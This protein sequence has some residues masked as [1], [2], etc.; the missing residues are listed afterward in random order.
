[1]DN[2][3]YNRIVFRLC[4][5]ALIV[6]SMTFAIRA[7]ILGQLGGDFGLTD[8]ELGWVN[9][10][11]F[12]GFPVATM[13]GG[14]IYN[15]IGA[16][17]LVALAFICHLL[18]LAL[19][20]TAD[21]FWGLLVSTFLIG[22]ANG[23]VEAGCNPLIAEMYPKNATTML[24][25]FHVWFPGGIVIGA[26]ASNFM[27]A[28]GLNW[29]WQ[30]ALILVP[31]IIYGAML[32]KAKFPTFDTRIHSTSSNIRHLFTPLYL[33]LIACMTLTATTEFGTQQWIER[34]L[35]SSGASPMVILALI[36][37]LMAV[38]RFFAGPIVH[39]LN[40]TGVLLGSALCASL[41]I[42]MMSQA[43]GT[44]IYLAAILFAMGVTYFWPTML[45][46]VAEYIPKSGALGMSLMGGAGM[47]AM[48][49]WNPVIGSWIDSARLSAKAS[50]ASAEQIEILA[51]Q[52]VLQNLLI[53]PII[54]IVAFIGLH[55]VI[56]NNKRA[57]KC[58]S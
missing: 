30:V 38:G 28:A 32:I 2:N 21:G 15:A 41:G 19:T 18:G 43:Q 34:I 45:G 53:F 26:L 40:P 23:S 56:N 10:M 33:F 7:G 17:K 25:R 5:I 27:S 4:C 48:S 36:T 42:F 6:T 55:L 50:G 20:I 16:K 9:A 11:A 29:Q 8:T 54:L 31:T 49:I 58:A 35:G 39:K 3:N 24:N 51:G 22:F 44:M 13:L 12:L 1:M 47:F 37:G 14:I 46:C 52:A 57:E